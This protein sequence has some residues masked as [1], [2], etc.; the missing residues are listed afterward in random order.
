MLLSQMEPPPRGVQKATPGLGTNEKGSTSPEIKLTPQRSFAVRRGS[1]P[2]CVMWP[3][4]AAALPT[5]PS[6]SSC[7]GSAGANGTLL[8]S[9][10]SSL[11]SDP[12]VLGPLEQAGLAASQ[13]P[14]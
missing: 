2:V 6:P 1:G 10:L 11:H 4:R 13:S 3:L 12:R 7:L 8:Q 9:T 5:C 14:H